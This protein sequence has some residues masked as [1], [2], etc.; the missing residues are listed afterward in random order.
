MTV[1]AHLRLFVAIEPPQNWLDAMAE[2]QER[3]RRALS[4]E[5]DTASLRLRWAR[6]EGTHLTLKF[7]GNVEESRLEAIKQQ[8][9]AAVPEPPGIELGLGR[10][11]T[12][13]DRR[14]PRVLWC[15]I[16]TQQRER[17]TQ[18]AERIETWL[19]AAG[20]PR[21]RGAFRPHLT[22]ARIPEDLS[23]AQR[24]RAAEITM[25]VEP[26]SAP[27]FGVQRVSLMLSHLGPGGSR[28]ERLAAFPD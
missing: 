16:E 14:A 27:P 9:A 23:E 1:E 25:G 13:S 12:F 20:V 22:L 5:P 19:E 11:G 15:A 2:L 18:L 26:A 10:A 3:M 8:L 24:R 7:I 21:E 6:P 28:Y 4:T 17:L